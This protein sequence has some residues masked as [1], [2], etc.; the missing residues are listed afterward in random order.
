[1]PNTPPFPIDGI[2]LGAAS[3]GSELPVDPG[4]HTVT[5]K[6][7]G[8]KPFTNSFNIAEKEMKTVEITLEHAPAVDDGQPA[9]PD[10]S[11]RPGPRDAEP[12]K[13][14]LLIPLVVGGAGVASL[15][16]SGI[17]FAL[18]SSAIKDL[19]N[20]CGADHVSCPGNLQSTYDHGKTYNVVADVTLILGIAGVGTG[21][22]LYFMQKSRTLHR[23]TPRSR[24]CPAHPA[25]KPAPLSSAASNRAALTEPL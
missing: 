18:R 20:G 17:F 21:A 12:R 13:S 23:R 9:D 7:P 25:H 24:S 3:I 4:P 16:T 19:D 2:S 8:Y 6:A 10:S 5:A 22:V 15:I 14:T 11:L 1:V